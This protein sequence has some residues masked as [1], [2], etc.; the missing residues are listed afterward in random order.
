[1]GQ[2]IVFSNTPFIRYS[3]TPNLWTRDKDHHI[4]LSRKEKLIDHW[5]QVAWNG[6]RFSAPTE[7]E[8]GKIG[9]RHLI[10]ED[11]AGPVMEVKW[12]TV[13]GAFSHK[14]LLKRLTASQ[15]GKLKNGLAEWFLPPPWQEALAGFE[16]SGLLWQ[17]QQ[18]S[19]RGAILFCRVCRCATLVQ[20]FRDSSAQSEKVLL[21]VLKSFQDHRQDGCTLWSVFDIRA[22]LPAELRLVRHRFEAGKYELLFNDGK[23]N[24]Y[25]CRWA[26]AAAILGGRDLAWFSGTIAGLEAAQPHWVTTDDDQ[27]LEAVRAPIGTWRRAIC[28]LKIK[29]SFFWYRLWHLQEKNRILSVRAESKTPLDGQFLNRICA[30]YD[31]L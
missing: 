29:P 9:A 30:D 15:S 24:V 28:R 27:A 25:L 10:L 26:P 19:G 22:K 8:V 21:S 16:A 1:L 5:R 12:G 7:W 20:F 17:G 6:V 3:I 31:S 2:G 11:E 14:T 4:Q 18:I 23:Q 13:Q